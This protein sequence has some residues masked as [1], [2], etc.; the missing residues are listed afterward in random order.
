MMLEDE[1]D[2]EAAALLC[3]QSHAEALLVTR[4]KDGMSLFQPAR[5]SLHIP[6]NGR[7]VFDVTG[8][9]G[10]VIAT[11]SMALLCGLSFANAALLANTAAGIVLGESRDGRGLPRR[12]TGSAPLGH[13]RYLQQARSLSDCLIVAL[14]DEPPCTGS[15]G[16]SAL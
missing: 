16:S 6:A 10:T 13:L 2:L 4:G 9:G 5:A 14:N 15:K 8:A 7:D 11:F 12:A 3:Q 1:S